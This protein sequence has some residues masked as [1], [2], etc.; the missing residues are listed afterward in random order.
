MKEDKDEWLE[1]PVE[2]EFVKDEGEEWSTVGGSAGCERWIKAASA[3]EPKVSMGLSSRSY[4]YVL[5]EEQEEDDVL[6]EEQEEDEVSVQDDEG[7]NESQEDDA[8]LRGWK[9]WQMFLMP[10]IK[11]K[12]K[13]R[14]KSRQAWSQR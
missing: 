9:I 13:R 5:Q 10:M 1:T 11:A 12:V 14:L 2:I 4:H 7:T 6:Q 8:F 3:Q